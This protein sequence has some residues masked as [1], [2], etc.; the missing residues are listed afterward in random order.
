MLIPSKVRYKLY[1]LTPGH[2]QQ[3]GRKYFIVPQTS[4]L[5]ES[6]SVCPRPFSGALKAKRVS[7]VRDDENPSVYVI[8]AVAHGHS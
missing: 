3:P 7:S 2:L 4:I 5:G 1:C 6:C 8:M